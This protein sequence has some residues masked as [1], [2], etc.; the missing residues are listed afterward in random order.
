LIPSKP[1]RAG[2]G[3]FFAFM[4]TAARA[5]VLA[6]LFV[7]MYLAAAATAE[8]ETRT[9]KLYYIHTGERAQIT[10]KRNG[11]YDQAG[12]KKLNR[13]LRDWRRNEPTKMDPQLFDIIWEAYKLVGA[14]DYI[15]VVSAYRSSA[16]NAMLRRTRG[17][18]AKKS[19]H[20]YGRAMDFYIPGVKLSKLREVGFKLQG[21]G[22]GYYPKS[23][24]PFVHF[25]TGNVRAWPRMSR[26]ELARIFPNGK[27]LHLPADGKAL[28]GYNQ[29]LAEYKSRKARGQATAVASSRRFTSDKVASST[30]NSRRNSDDDSNSGSGRTLIS[31]LFGG[32]A[33]E[34]EDNAETTATRTRSN[35]TASAP[36]APQRVEPPVETPG[37][38]IASLSARETPL[39]AAAPRTR[40][41][42]PLDQQ[43]QVT[44]ASLTQD[45]PRPLALIPQPN[46]KPTPL[47]A[48]LE[49]QPRPGRRSAAELEAAL[50]GS[51]SETALARETV[52]PL[53]ASANTD[54]GTA[55]SN[56]LSVPLPVP[57]P[58]QA[59]ADRPLVAVAALPVP[60]TRNTTTETSDAPLAVAYAPET[61]VP[62]LRPQ[63]AEP[64]VAISPD[65][66]ARI[67]AA[68]DSGVATTSKSP[69][70][71]PARSKKPDVKLVSADDID[72]SRFGGW[73]TASISITDHGRA[74]ERPVF[75]RNALREAPT[76]VYT[77]GFQKH[78]APDPRRFSGGNAITFLTVARFA[79][80]R[81]GDGEPLTLQL[82]L[83][84]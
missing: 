24:S 55:A 7:P 74:A 40:P 28:P 10:F 42:I 78:A 69:R 37:T 73:T 21:G 77:D 81:G 64:V 31:A 41:I 43:P 54:P 58:R 71:A 2:Y 13:F 75:I 32:G 1:F 63:R 9:L 83:A 51:R 14:R 22:V 47:I 8:A 61:A 36:A 52:E 49:K 3:P 15:H 17:G 19:Q 76:E 72:P 70:P 79:G 39:P 45:V 67:R 27:T 46:A 25:D 16:T 59:V 53:I 68:Y 6:C 5:A 38:I 80:G 62:A 20:M 11:R 35:A 26:G 18:Q 44:I 34:E 12:L 57:A 4:R 66:E 65:A 30:S 48:G 60:A 82:P 29:A 84:N 33:D 23:G 56:A 50:N